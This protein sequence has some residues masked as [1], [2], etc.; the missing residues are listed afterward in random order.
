MS[1][2]AADVQGINAAIKQTG[3]DL[4]AFA[5]KT[6]EQY[7]EVK[8]R[9]QQVEQ[10]VANIEPGAAYGGPFDGPSAGRLAAQALAEDGDLDRLARGNTTSIG[11]VLDGVSLRAAMVNEGGGSSDHNSYPSQPEQRGAFGPG[12]RRLRLLDVLPS[13][14]TSSDSV[15]FVRISST[16]EAAEQIEEAAEKQNLDFEGELVK[17]DIATVA[18]HTTI[19]KQALGDQGSLTAAINRLLSHKVLSRFE[20]LLV[21]G[22]VG[23]TVS[24]IDG[25]LELGLE[26]VPTIATTPADTVGEAL[27]RQA[28]AGYMPGLILLN[29]LDWFRIQLTRHT[30]ET[31]GYVFGSPTMPVPPAL[32]N[33]PIVASPSIAEGR[34]MTVDLAW[35][36]VLDREAARIQASNQ[37][38]KNFTRNLVT[39]LGEMRGGLEVIDPKAIYKFDL[40]AS[41]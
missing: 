3:S 40:E 1:A 41:S 38:D 27:V 33:T 26:F 24:R 20:Y 8:A 6:G 9:V 31:E 13:R 16:D 14:P 36:T 17:A 7:D 4:R 15:T 2:T 23:A 32:W 21:N 10:M 35:V 12:L 34:G 5:K 11:C 39:L 29:P 22:G 19:S 28:D 37:H 30:V 18:G 25:L